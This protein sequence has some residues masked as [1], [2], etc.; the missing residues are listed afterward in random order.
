MKKW[1]IVALGLQQAAVSWLEQVVDLN[2]AP[3]AKR[4][5]EVVLDMLEE[6]QA[7]APRLPIDID[8]ERLK[9]AINAWDTPC[10]MQDTH[11]DLLVRVAK[12]FVPEPNGY[13]LQGNDWSSHRHTLEEILKAAE[14]PIERGETVTLKRGIFPRLEP[15]SKT[16]T[17]NAQL[18]V[19]Q[20]KPRP[21]GKWRV[22]RWYHN[23]QAPIEYLAMTFGEV[24]DHVQYGLEDGDTF[25]SV[26]KEQA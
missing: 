16:P 1:K 18:L 21:T 10:V 13:T 24:L 2:P 22:D 26:K 25:I 11:I 20:R 15:A 3:D 8:P 7:K 12:L 9:N 4:Y 14:G 5:A 19:Q 17:G 6:A 23:T